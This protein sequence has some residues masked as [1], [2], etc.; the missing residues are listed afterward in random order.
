MT[1]LTKLE[2]DDVQRVDNVLADAKVAPL[3]RRS[4]VT[5]AATGVAA[6][7]ASGRL[8]Q[9]PPHLPTMNGIPSTRS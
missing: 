5:R 4:L 2:S 6:V 7:G 3:T 1:D 8:G 9:S